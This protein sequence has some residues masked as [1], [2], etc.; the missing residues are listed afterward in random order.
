M[1][2]KYNGI[3]GKT[4]G[5]A[6]VRSPAAKIAAMEKVMVMAT[7]NSPSPLRGSSALAIGNPGT[8]QA[9]ARCFC[10]AIEPEQWHT[11]PARL[12]RWLAGQH[13]PR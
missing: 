11:P 9:F 1:V 6:N 3:K 10:V 4:H 8:R 5:E 2:A 7:S 12:V 13:L